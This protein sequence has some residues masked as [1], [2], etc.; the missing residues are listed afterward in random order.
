M[1]RKLERMRGIEMGLGEVVKFGVVDGVEIGEGESVVIG[2]WALWGFVIKIVFVVIDGVVG[3]PFNNEAV[4]LEEGH[5]VADGKGLDAS[6]GRVRDRKLG[7]AVS[8]N[9]STSGEGDEIVR[10][11]DVSGRVEG[12]GADGTSGWGVGGGVIIK[13]LR[14]CAEFDSHR[15]VVWTMVSCDNVSRAGG[16]GDAVGAWKLVEAASDIRYHVLDQDLG[17]SA[18]WEAMCAYANA[19]L[20][21]ADGAL[22]FANVSIGRNDVEMDGEDVGSDTVELF[23]GVDVF[24]DDTAEGIEL[25]DVAS[26]FEYRGVRPVGDLN[27]CAVSNATGNGVQKRNP[28]DEEKFDA[29]SNVPVILMYRRRDRHSFERWYSRHGTRS[30]HLTLECGDGGAVDDEGPMRVVRSDG[31]IDDEIVL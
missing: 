3:A 25:D 1:I 5:F 31:T 22:D 14:I 15:I 24:D 9:A 20:D 29:K 30:R 11:L 16:L 18:I 28:L 21:G 6:D 26:V 4:F 27:G 12:N 10:S 23:V 2:G 19:L 8:G 7:P 17:E 13:H